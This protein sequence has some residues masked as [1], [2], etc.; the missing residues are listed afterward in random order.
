MYLQAID[1]DEGR[2]RTIDEYFEL[3]RGTIGVRPSWDYYLLSSDIP[4]E[5][6]AHPHVERLA[7]AAIDMTILANVRG[8]LLT[9]FSEPFI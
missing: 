3:R 9:S 1:R 4:D 8:S 5:A 2:I 7:I 6:I